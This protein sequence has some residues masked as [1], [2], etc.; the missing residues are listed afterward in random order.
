LEL[1]A[2][3]EQAAAGGKW[4]YKCRFMMWWSRDIWHKKLCF[5][6]VQSSQTIWT[7]GV[8]FAFVVG[9]SSGRGLGLGAIATGAMP[10]DDSIIINL[11]GDRDFVL[12][13]SGR[14]ARWFVFKPK[15]RAIDHYY[16]YNFKLVLTLAVAAR[17]HLDRQ[18]PKTAY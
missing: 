16:I 13:G 4:S 15:E 11:C 8:A 6:S 2:G 5:L 3:Q 14:V 10:G 17:L 1:Q 7:D 12:I 18:V 9:G